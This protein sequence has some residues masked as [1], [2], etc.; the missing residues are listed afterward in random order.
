MDL[1][2]EIDWV[3]VSYRRARVMGLEGREKGKRRIS[4]KSEGILG[5]IVELRR[6]CYLEIGRGMHITGL[7]RISILKLGSYSHASFAASL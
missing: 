5:V 3:Q 1:R 2:V 7:Y 6:K 4:G